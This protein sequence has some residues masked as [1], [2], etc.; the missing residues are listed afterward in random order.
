MVGSFTAL[1]LTAGEPRVI[2]VVIPQEVHRQR[3][4][5]LRCFVTTDLPHTLTDPPVETMKVT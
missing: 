3:P 5:W 2:E 4:Y 1:A